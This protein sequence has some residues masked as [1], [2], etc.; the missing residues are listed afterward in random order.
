MKSCEIVRDRVQ[1]CDPV[2]HMIRITRRSQAMHQMSD[3]AS[4]RGGV[5]HEAPTGKLPQAQRG[6]W[7][8][9]RKGE[10]L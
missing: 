10:V 4:R 1:S 3:Y 2:S 5:C 7:R 9:L 8:L 6:E